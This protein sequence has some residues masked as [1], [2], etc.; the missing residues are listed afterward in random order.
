MWQVE[1]RFRKSV[2]R[3]NS[4]PVNDSSGTR[5][6]EQKNPGCVADV[7]LTQAQ[8]EQAARPSPACR[9]AVT[10]FGASEPQPIG[11]GEEVS[12]L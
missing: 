11:A 8:Q 5:L 7:N 2:E 4:Q 1:R 3:A 12:F 10:G 6:Q 9:A